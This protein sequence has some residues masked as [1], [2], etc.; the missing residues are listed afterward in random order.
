[1]WMVVLKSSG[2][3]LHA[4][5]FPAEPDNKSMVELE[6][7]FEE[8]SMDDGYWSWLIIVRGGL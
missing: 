3:M 6:K 8:G 7:W 1:M 2:M 4:L 5:S